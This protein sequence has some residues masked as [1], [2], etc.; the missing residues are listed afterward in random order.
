M[1]KTGGG[2]GGMGDGAW[3]ALTLIRTTEPA[4]DPARSRRKRTRH[5]AISLKYSGLVVCARRNTTV[6]VKEFAWFRGVDTKRGDG[7]YPV[8][9]SSGQRGQSV[10]HTS[11]DGNY[12]CSL[13][14]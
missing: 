13:G 2:E 9:G 11:Q 7:L 1:V 8:A 5:M 3:A 10:R 6:K 14:C 4:I 12:S